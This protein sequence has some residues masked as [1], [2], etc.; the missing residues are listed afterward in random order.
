MTP[1]ELLR[2]HL[3]GRDFTAT[4]PPT[5]EV[6]MVAE[7]EEMQAVLVRYPFGIPVELIVEESMD[8]SVLTI[9]ENAAEEL[10]VRDIYQNAGVNMVNC[11]FVY[12]QSDSYWTRDYG[13]WFVVNGDHEVGVCDFPYNRPRPNDDEIPVVVA[14]YLGIELYGMP[15][16]QT[17]GN[18][19]CDGY[20]KAASTDLVWEE[21]TNISHDSIDN[22]VEQYLGVEKYH[23]LPD[24]LDDYIK[25]IDCWGK[26]L[27]V[28]KVL[29][30]QVPQSDYR[31]DDFEYVA[32]YFSFHASGYGTPYEVYRIYTPGDYPYTPYTNSLI[33]NKKVFVP[34]T[35]SAHD[36]PAL[37]VYEEAMPGYE[38]I[39]VLHNNWVNSDALHCRN[40]GIADVGMLH[41]KHMPLLGNKQFKLDWEIEADIIPCSGFGVKPDSL[42]L[43]YSVDGGAYETMQLETVENHTY[44]ATLPFQ[45]PGAEVAYYLHA[46]DFS[47]RTK[48]H[49]Y[50]GE[51]DP[52]VFTVMHATDI[53]VNPDSLL[54]L[55]EDDVWFGLPLDIY[56]F[57]SGNIS[58]E[59]VEQG[60]NWW[61]VTPFHTYP[62]SMNS[63]DTL[64]L[65]VMINMP[66]DYTGTLWVDT[67]DILSENGLHQVILKVDEDLIISIPE[68][69]KP[70]PLTFNSIYPNPFNASTTLS[71]SLKIE[72]HVCVEIYGLN[73]Q[74]ITT[75]VNRSIASG[76]HQFTWNGCGTDGT[77]VAE[78]MYLMK[79]EGADFVEVKKIVLMR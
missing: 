16:I 38:I 78:G 34:I 8:C 73:G 71:F 9:V 15:L 31:Y 62:Y 65:M 76:D 57:T 4:D 17:G 44:N 50:I 18:W 6:R 25:H 29:I 39:G 37:Q 22:L 74:K 36:A 33:L 70:S 66:V 63:F 23:V 3:I 67:L 46:A 47:G 26:F 61:F 77:A 52:H 28:D 30:G 53:T 75:L 10:T 5:G 68:P 48:E 40:K 21:N 79:I 11:E 45:E 59:N 19:M 69:G 32:N 41:I 13:P 49:P 14:N 60:E 54:F 7:F 24:P 35:G 56:N 58:I 12:A 72:D 51:P 42:L 20:G 1:E 27:D 55:T 43:Y 2:K 64:S